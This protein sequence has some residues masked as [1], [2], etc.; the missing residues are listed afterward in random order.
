MEGTLQLDS[1][2]TPAFCSIPSCHSLLPPDSTAFHLPSTGMLVCCVCYK[3]YLKNEYERVV[4]AERGAVNK[5]S[6]C[7]LPLPE[8]C[9]S[10]VGNNSAAVFDLEEDSMEVESPVEQWSMSTA[11]TQICPIPN[12]SNTRLQCS[13]EYDSIPP[14]QYQESNVLCNNDVYQIPSYQSEINFNSSNVDFSEN[15]AEIL[16]YTTLE[17]ASSSTCP[18]EIPITEN[19]GI[20]CQEESIAHPAGEQQ[21]EAQ[22]DKNSETQEPQKE[23][24]QK[25]EKC[26]NNVCKQTLIMEKIYVHPVTKE[27]I[28]KICYNYYKRN[29]RDREVIITCRREKL[30]THCSNTFCKQ[31]LVPRNIRYHS[32][33][34]EKIC[35]ACFDYYKRNGRD[36]EVIR[37]YKKREK[38]ETNSCYHYFK[39]TGR[40]REVVA[41]K[42]KKFKRDEYKNESDTTPISSDDSSIE[43]SSESDYESVSSEMD[44]K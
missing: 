40:D 10:S 35:S 39:R 38:H 1:T 29:G 13:E 19:P 27:K 15:S 33:T 32:I 11:E 7:S 9:K 4:A 31:A 5:K 30:E 3:L 34:K 41:G 44:C 6:E 37:T 18:L 21:K 43:E 23:N 42:V 28:C 2:V 8:A 24:I 25:G 36:R 26:A 14:Y 20:N 12:L 17:S 16:T 22:S